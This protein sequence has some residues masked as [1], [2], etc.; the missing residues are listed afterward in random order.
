[1][2]M[3]KTTRN[4]RS[5]EVHQEH[6]LSGRVA[7]RS[8]LRQILSLS[9]NLILNESQD[10]AQAPVKAPGKN[11]QPATTEEDEGYGTGEEDDEDEE[12]EYEVD[13][14]EDEEGGEEGDSDDEEDYEDD[15]DEGDIDADGPA[16]AAGQ[17]DDHRKI[18]EDFYAPVRI[19]S[20]LVHWVLM[21]ISYRKGAITPKMMKRTIRRITSLPTKSQAGPRGR[22]RVM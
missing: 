8:A 1:M 15:D 13:D 11:G 20:G 12:D 4:T 22:L 5:V 7:M 19:V 16:G 14:E 17:R 18:L 2:R 10:D 9:N 21:L 3:R 6:T